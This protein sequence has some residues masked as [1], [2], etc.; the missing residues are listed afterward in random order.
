M[1]QFVNNDVKAEPKA[2][3]AKFHALENKN[4]Q[5]QLKY[6]TMQRNM[7][8]MTNLSVKGQ[9]L[10]KTQK[11][12]RVHNQNPTVTEREEHNPQQPPPV[13]TMYLPAIKT[14][15]KKRNQRKKKTASAGRPPKTKKDPNPKET[16]PSTPTDGTIHH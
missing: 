11:T 14:N 16:K 1:K 3:K 7:N 8:E 4:K 2:M 12:V 5:A 15:Q 10:S 9:G 6:D 13:S